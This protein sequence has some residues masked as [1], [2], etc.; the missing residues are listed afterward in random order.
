MLNV[1][2]IS[3]ELVTGFTGILRVQNVLHIAGVGADK[4][5]LELEPITLTSVES[6][7]TV[8]A[9][10]SQEFGLVAEQLPEIAE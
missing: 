10:L 9:Y 3:P 1:N 8:M 6:A 4:V 7:M 5:Q 2:E